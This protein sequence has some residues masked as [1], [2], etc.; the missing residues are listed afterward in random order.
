MPTPPIPTDAEIHDAAKRLGLLDDEGR[1]PRHQRK[2]IAKSIQLAKVDDQAATASAE[3][4]LKFCDEI[5]GIYNHLA[6]AMPAECTAA[7]LRAV[8]PR[9]HAQSTAQP[10]GTAP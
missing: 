7:V 10:E 6:G 9:I 5:V 3:S 4:R 8:A 1:V 2:Q